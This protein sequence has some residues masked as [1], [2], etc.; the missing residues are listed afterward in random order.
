LKL[1]KAAYIAAEKP[2]AV[3][4]ATGDLSGLLLHMIAAPRVV[5]TVQTHGAPLGDAAVQ[6]SILGGREQDW[7]EEFRWAN[8]PRQAIAADG[9]YDVALPATTGQFAVRVVAT[10][11]TVAT[12]PAVAITAGQ[13]QYRVDLEIE[14]GGALAGRVVAMVGG[15]PVRGARVRAMWLAPGVD[16]DQ[17][18]RGPNPEPVVAVGDGDGRFSVTSLRSG[19][20]ELRVSADGFLE[21]KVE[22][23]V[24]Q[25][26]ELVVSLPPELTL[27]GHIV[28]RDGQPVAAAQVSPEPQQGNRLMWTSIEQVTMS[29]P[30]GRFKIPRLHPGQYRISVHPP[31]T[32]VSNF[33]PSR[34]S[35][36]AAGAHDVRIVVEPGA[37]ISGRV[38]DADQRGLPRVSVGAQISGGGGGIGV[39]TLQDGTFTLIG[40]EDGATYTVSVNVDNWGGRN[41][42]ASMQRPNVAAGT[43]G[44]EFVLQQGLAVDGVV[45]D[46]D[47]KPTAGVEVTA[48]AV[49]TDL[50]YGP[51]AWT[52]Q[53]GKFAIR[54]L[55][56]GHYRLAIPQWF[57]RGLLL[58]GGDDVAAGTS[59]LRL[60]ATE[61]AKIAGIIVDEAD[62]PVGSAEVEAEAMQAGV[63]G[64]SWTRSQADGRFQI[65]G[66]VANAS[67]RV[68]ARLRGRVPATQSATAGSTD[69]RLQL[70]LGLGVR[71][72]L[73]DAS[74]NALADTNLSLVN[75]TTSRAVGSRTDAEGR[76]AATGLVAGTYRVE[77]WTGAA[78]HLVKQDCG[79]V[80]AGQEDVELRLRQ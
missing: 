9:T 39:E 4:P 3:I 79:T 8:T 35:I 73:L 74:G 29:A 19:R 11:R 42:F 71:G 6:V 18:M 57:S 22:V 67:Y 7:Q 5:G 20:C 60:T 59:D 43:T 48:V 69:L 51:V 61:G 75:A 56:A 46:G 65:S 27:E 44:L 17:M 40:L 53:D 24:P 62:A 38:T 30:D 1:Q 28:Y 31:R 58:T 49:G 78:N 45:V 13:D 37:S 25:T 2:T 41:P 66:L 36:V 64:G 70:V 23:R 80:E 14:G 54:G 32:G 26:G 33:R 21:E 16:A 72:R 34:S 52:D 76:F 12:S 55:R 15:E 63:Q 68:A 77:V 50:G 47:G 10:G